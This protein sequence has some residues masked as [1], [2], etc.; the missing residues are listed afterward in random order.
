M[1]TLMIM[2]QGR[3]ENI[4]L[5]KASVWKAIEQHARLNI[6]TTAWQFR[7]DHTDTASIIKMK[8]FFSSAEI[9]LESESTSYA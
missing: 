7:D 2:Q 5:L 4:Q 1:H 6:L 8:T 9:Q 3:W